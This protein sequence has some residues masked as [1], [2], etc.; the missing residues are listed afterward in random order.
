MAWLNKLW[1]HCCER[2]RTERAPLSLELH[3]HSR[4]LCLT[5][6]IACLTI[7]PGMAMPGQVPRWPWPADL[8]WLDLSPVMALSP[9]WASTWLWVYP[10][11][12]PRLARSYGT[13]AGEDRIPW[14]PWAPCTCWG[15]WSVLW[16]GSN[17][18]W[19]TGSFQTPSVSR[20]VYVL[21][22]IMQLAVSGGMLSLYFT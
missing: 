10:G 20:D 7:A 15:R 17:L 14:P 6:P 4:P 19:P 2:A 18:G 13:L 16:P 5:L 21:H 3:L 1:S 9:C 11:H 8:A 12:I 22:C